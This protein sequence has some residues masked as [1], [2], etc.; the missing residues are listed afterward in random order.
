MVKLI[1]VSLVDSYIDRIDW[2]AVLGYDKHS[3]QIFLHYVPKTLIMRDVEICRKW[4]LGIVDEYG[5][6][7][8]DVELLEV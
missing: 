2:I 3:N 5:R 1:G 8:E 4:V 6:I 7:V